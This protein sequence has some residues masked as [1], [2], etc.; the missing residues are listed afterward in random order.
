MT[1]V[2]VLVAAGITTTVLGAVLSVTVPAHRLF[3]VQQESTDIQQRLRVSVV[4]I[5][6][7]LRGAGL[8]LPYRAGDVGDDRGAGVHYRPDAVTALVGPA[9]A[10]ARGGPPPLSRT[11][12]L[13]APPGTAPQLMRYDGLATSMPVVDNVVR[14]TFDYVGEAQPPRVRP[15]ANPAEPEIVSYGPAPPALGVDEPGDDWGPGENCVFT[16][17]NGR[18]APRLAVVA[19]GGVVPLPAGLLTDGPWCPD[20][21]HPRRFDADLL[22]VRSI[23]LR[24]RVQAPPAFRGRAGALFVTPGAAIPGLAVPDEELS[25]DVAP[26]TMNGSW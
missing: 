7:D 10:Y 22:R 23:R 5:A 12:Y 17:L 14:L 15:S 19:P 26:R 8:L 9:D 25:I 20:A 13:D 1:L 18:R 4:T 3:E 24:I 2:E 11:Y 21:L 16:T 6:D